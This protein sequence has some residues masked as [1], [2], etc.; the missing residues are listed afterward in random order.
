MKIASRR[1]GPENVGSSWR[2]RQN[3]ADE[4]GQPPVKTLRLR[5]GGLSPADQHQLDLPMSL[6]ADN[7]HSHD[8]NV[9]SECDVCVL[10][11]H[12]LFYIQ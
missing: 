7:Y 11:D 10:E 3:T 5:G 8:P 9:V 1:A 2:R 4:Q 6:I 12:R